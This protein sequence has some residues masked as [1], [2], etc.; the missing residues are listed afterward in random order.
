M[1]GKLLGDFKTFILRGNVVDLAVGVVIGAAFQ[2]VVKAFV[3]DVISPIIPTKTP[4]GL[5]TLEIPIY[6]G[7][8]LGNHYIKIGDF[9]NTL[10]SFLMVAAVIFFLV[11]RPINMLTTLSRR[12]ISAEETH[13]DCP[14]C[15]SSIPIKATRCAFCTSE[16]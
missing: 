6:G 2:T 8:I 11:V 9:V 13:R 5:A 16:V 15:L 1:F 12:V 14:F 3:D 7:Q 4:Q 10:V